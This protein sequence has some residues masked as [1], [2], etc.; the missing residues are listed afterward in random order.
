[1]YIDVELRGKNEETSS[2]NN[3]TKNEFKLASP[4]FFSVSSNCLQFVVTGLAAVFLWCMPICAKDVLCFSALSLVPVCVA[5]CCACIW[6]V[7]LPCE[8]AC[9]RA[10][11][12]MYWTTKNAWYGNSFS[13]NFLQSFQQEEWLSQ[14]QNNTQNHRFISLIPRAVSN[15]FWVCVL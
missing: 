9:Y 12:Y 2:W 4:P 5:M 3:L 8:C 15:I 14:T 10:S 13:P 7:P 11:P 6:C 1:M